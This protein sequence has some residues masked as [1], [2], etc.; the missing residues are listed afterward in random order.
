M[1]QVF[2][3]GPGRQR[4]HDD[5]PEASQVWMPYHAMAITA[6]IR[7]GEVGA[8]DAERDAGDHRVGHAGGLA[9]VAGEF[10]RKKTT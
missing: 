5:A 2:E 4:E 8:E 1:R 9:G 10:I 7:A 3:A 6:R